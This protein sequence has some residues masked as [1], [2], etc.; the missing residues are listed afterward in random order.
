MDKQ[1]NNS[2]NNNTNNDNDRHHT[3]AQQYGTQATIVP[4]PNPTT[5]TLLAGGKRL[6]DGFQPWPGA[7]LL[8]RFLFTH[9]ARCTEAKGSRDFVAFEQIDSSFLDYLPIHE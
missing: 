4:T 7:L 2:N 9:Q 1:Q 8:F 3:A 6:N 5:T